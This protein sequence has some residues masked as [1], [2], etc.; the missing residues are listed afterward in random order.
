MTW[1]FSVLDFIQTHLRSEAGDAVMLHITNS[2]RIWI[3]LALAM[4]LHPKTRKT[5]AALVVALVLEVLC[6]NRILKPLV[7]RVRPC[8]IN[9]AVQLL[10]PRPSDFSFPSGHTGT[11]LAAASALYF[12][13]CRLRVP[14]LVFAA[15]MGFTRLYLYVHYPS[16]VLAGAALGM[17]LG[18][19]SC[20]LVRFVER[21]FCR[22]DR[23]ASL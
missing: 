4:L 18:W 21:K 13:G 11:S 1:E 7:A 23:S 6:C 15:L 8:D 5:G 16:D 3:L 19:L 14:A 10:I 9:T 17:F 12:S 2:G 20:A 22:R